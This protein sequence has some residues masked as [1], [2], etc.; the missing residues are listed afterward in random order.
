MPGGVILRG[1]EQVGQYTQALWT[2]FPDGAL[3]FGDQLFGEDAAATEVAFTGTQT[4][5]MSTPNST[6]PPTGKR[7]TLHSASILR[8][9]DEVV[10]SEHFYLDQF[11]MMTQLGLAT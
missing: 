9:K 1:R 10:A 11:E 7:V 8:I 3:A 4:G 5:P 6:I 2:A